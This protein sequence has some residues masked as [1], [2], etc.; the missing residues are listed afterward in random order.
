MFKKMI[1]FCKKSALDVIS[2]LV[3]LHL[4]TNRRIRVDFKISFRFTDDNIWFEE[5]N[6]MDKNLK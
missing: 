4:L 5:K 2:L 6:L 3:F 1:I